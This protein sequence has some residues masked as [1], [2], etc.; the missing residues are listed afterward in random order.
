VTKESGMNKKFFLKWGLQNARELFA[1]DD[2]IKILA[3]DP[4]F[5]GLKRHLDFGEKVG[6]RMA[7]MIPCFIVRYFFIKC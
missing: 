1:W 6:A 5:K 4:M 7:V 3:E 2:R